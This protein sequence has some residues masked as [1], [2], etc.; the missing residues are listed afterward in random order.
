ME[1]RAVIKFV[2]GFS[3]DRIA[4]EAED[5]KFFDIKLVDEGEQKGSIAWTYE[6]PTVKIPDEEFDVVLDW[7]SEK[8]CCDVVFSNGLVFGYVDDKDMKI[9]FRK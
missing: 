9:I 8:D 2:P 4:G 1:E 5:L 3:P 7:N 6:F